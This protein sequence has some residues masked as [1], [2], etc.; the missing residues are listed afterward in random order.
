MPVKTRLMIK[1]E[2]E[3]QQQSKKIHEP[4][5]ND[6]DEK[7]II[8]KN[9]YDNYKC[10][11]IKDILGHILRGNTFEVVIDFTKDIQYDIFS[12]FPDHFINQIRSNIKDRSLDLMKSVE[13]LRINQTNEYREL[14]I[15]IIILLYKYNEYIFIATNSMQDSEI[16]QIYIINDKNLLSI[17]INKIEEFKKTIPTSYSHEQRTKL[18]N[19]LDGYMYRIINYI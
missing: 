8:E 13:T 18:F 3:M 6:I 15:D 7:Y 4:K 17:S 11:L 19:A 16:K 14:L 12:E 9:L 1:K 5:L 2:Q 10:I